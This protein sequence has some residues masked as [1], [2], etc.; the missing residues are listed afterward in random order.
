[1]KNFI[2]GLI[3]FFGMGLFI[4]ALIAEAEAAEL[5]K[6]NE[7]KVTYVRGR[8]HLTCH[9]YYNGRYVTMHRTDSCPMAYHS[10]AS[11]SRFVDEGS[12]AYTVALTNHSNNN[13]KKTKT[14]YPDKGYS[15]HFN[16]LTRSLFQRPL[17]VEGI[18]NLTYQM[19]LKSGEVIDSG[20]F[21]VNVET[22][23]KYCRTG[24]MTSFNIDDCR[25]G[26]SYNLCDQYVYETGCLE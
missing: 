21:D 26:A 23:S 17:L 7:Y 2:I 15:K 3:V 9:G 19:I 8:L 10:P 11:Y 25:T 1:M 13:K 18:N 6:G 5:E 14:F 16:L 22:E 12:K 20:A 24:F 4:G